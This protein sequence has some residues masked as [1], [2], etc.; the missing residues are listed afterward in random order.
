MAV[1]LGKRKS[2]FGIKISEIPIGIGEDD[3]RSMFTEFGNIL[4]IVLKD[5]QPLNHAFINYDSP[6]SAADAAD[7]MN[8]CGVPGGVL[9]VK[10]QSAA[11]LSSAKKY[12]T[13][14]SV[15]NT[16]SVPSTMP[17]GN[18]SMGNT[19]QFTGSIKSRSTD[20]G[21]SVN[22]FSVKISNINPFTKQEELSRLF[23]TTVIVKDVVASS[24]KY[25][26]ANFKSQEEVE[27]AVKLNNALLDDLRI[28]VKRA[29]PLKNVLVTNNKLSAIHNLFL[30]ISAPCNSIPIVVLICFH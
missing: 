20:M 4:N 1:T 13:A 9:K 8:G 22:Q 15:A 2:A 14:A 7:R 23:K 12:R 29:G 18:L 26:Y 10:L 16:V 17:H 27:E 25:A 21:S 5:S 28:Q 24:K 11:Q 3:L 19:D 6:H 30:V